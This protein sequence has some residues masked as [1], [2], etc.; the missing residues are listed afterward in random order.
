[1]IVLF[2]ESIEELEE[3]YPDCS[4]NRKASILFRTAEKRRNT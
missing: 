3:K 2:G 1:L 4:A